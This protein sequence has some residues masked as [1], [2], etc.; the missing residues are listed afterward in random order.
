VKSFDSEHD[1]PGTLGFMIQNRLSDG[2]ICYITD[3]GFVKTAPKGV[4]TL[5]IECNYV[6]ELMDYSETK[7]VQMRT[8][9]SHMSLERLKS[10]LGKIDL[11]ELKTVVLVHLSDRHSNERQ[12]VREIQ[13]ITHAR[14]FAAHA[15]DIYDL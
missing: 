10:Y 8:K 11:S 7:E 15:G 1:L 12:M 3:S 14:V 13:E 6:D 4:Q 9:E 5:I 2:V